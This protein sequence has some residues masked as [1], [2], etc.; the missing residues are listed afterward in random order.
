M[1]G[2]TDILFWRRV[3]VPGLERMALHHHDDGVLAEASVLCLEDGGFQLTHRWRLDPLWRTLS[4]D[5][6]KLAGSNEQ[7]LRLE[8]T[9]D[10]W[11]VD[12]DHRPDLD[13]LDEPDLSVTPFCNTLPIRQM[14]AGTA[15][16]QVLSTCY[17]NAADMRVVASTQKYERISDTRFRYI[18]LGVFTGFEAVLDVDADGFVERY[19]GLFE[20]IR[21]A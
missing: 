12:G 21:P 18:D 17:I 11:A 4:L 2:K 13:G 1:T 7:R 6:V 20:R 9:R 3:D 8:R 15:S 10:G 5:V 16:S 19:E 14:L